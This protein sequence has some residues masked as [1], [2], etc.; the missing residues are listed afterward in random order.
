MKICSL[1]KSKYDDRVDFC[2]RDGT[3][4]VPVA[5]EA[6]AIDAPADDLYSSATRP[7]V[8]QPEGSPQGIDALDV[9][10]APDRFATGDGVDVPEPRFGFDPADAPEPPLAAQ[11]VIDAP[12]PASA[13]PVEP[14][15]TDAPA[16]S[17]LDAPEP[18][19]PLDAPPEPTAHD[20]PEPLAAPRPVSMEPSDGPGSSHS[21][22]M[23]PQE[24]PSA[25][26]V[27]DPAAAPAADSDELPGPTVSEGFGPS[28]DFDDSFAPIDDDLPDEESAS[29][30]AF[31]AESAYVPPPDQPQSNNRTLFIVFGVVG[32]AAVLVILWILFGMGGQPGEP[33]PPPQPDPVVEVA[34]RPAPTPA[35]PPAPV[36]DPIEDPLGEPGEQPGDDQAVADILELPTED[37]VEDPVVQPDPQPRAQP[38]TQPRT[39]PDPKP[40]PQPTSGGTSGDG[41]PWGESGSGGTTTTDGGGRDIWGS[42]GQAPPAGTKGSL[43]IRSNPMGAMVFVGNEMVGR[44]PLV[45]KELGEGSHMVRVELDGYSTVSKVANVKPGEA[46]DLGTVQLESQAPVSGYVTL[47]ADDLIGAKVYIDNQYVGE[48]PVKVELNEGPHAF[49]VQPAEGEAFTVDRDVHFDVQ[50]IGISIDLGRR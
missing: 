25:E 15:L 14:D 16:P 9:P 2:F 5:D 10:D 32:V 28:D 39:Q 4:L 34:P 48:L 19:V 44:T 41:S 8:V 33:V 26:A 43:T 49:F 6:A 20:A 18:A 11:A 27:A 45:G 47:W 1:C 35:P 30:P 17:F 40:D 24:E 22:T 29:A 42:G 23:V 38:R 7:F 31:G 3:P 37:P 50:G 21:E 46:A 36:P 12:E 13:K